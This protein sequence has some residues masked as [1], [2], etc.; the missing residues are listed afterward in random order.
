M[1]TPSWLLKLGLLGGMVYFYKNH[2]ET[3]KTV[4]ASLPE[5]VNSLREKATHLATGTSWTMTE[6]SASLSLE[7]PGVKSP[8]IT[9]IDE[10]RE[11]RIQGTRLDMEPLNRTVT[12]PDGVNLQSLSAAVADGIV[13]LKAAKNAEGRVLPVNAESE[14]AE[15]FQKV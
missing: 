7:M 1:F 6:K 4:G 12:V 3:S 5:I 9:V 14:G 8:Q 11:I 10:K 13:T 15:E 2:P